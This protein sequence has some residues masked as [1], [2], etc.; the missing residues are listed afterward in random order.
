MHIYIFSELQSGTLNNDCWTDDPEE[1]LLSD[2]DDD[3]T[4]AEED[5]TETN[6]A[7]HC[8]ESLELPGNEHVV[9]KC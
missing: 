9:S 6:V 4:E 7:N 2:A 8:E 1:Q 3:F 5:F